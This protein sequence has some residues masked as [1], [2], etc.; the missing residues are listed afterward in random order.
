MLNRSHITAAV[1]MA[2]FVFSLPSHAESAADYVGN[3][4]AGGASSLNAPSWANVYATAGWQHMQPTGQSS[5]LTTMIPFAGTVFTQV[6]PKSALAAGSSDTPDLSVGYFFTPHIAAELS[7]GLPA[8]FDL[9][10][11]GDMSSLGTVA[12]AHVFAPTL[13][14]K[15]FF[16]EPDGLLDESSSLISLPYGL[17]PFLG[18]GVSHVSFSDAKFANAALSGDHTMSIRGAWEPVFALGAS[19]TLSDHWFVMASVSYM[20]LHP[21]ATVNADEQTPI[22]SA[23]TQTTTRLHINPIVSQLSI[24]YKF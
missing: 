24:G 3:L 13:M 20:P 7:A 10:G 8:K 11:K 9:Q 23:R 2:S 12:S 19:Y 17:R 21:V 16:N 4:E 6:D 1:L 22:G 18:I 5:S 15:Y 14:F